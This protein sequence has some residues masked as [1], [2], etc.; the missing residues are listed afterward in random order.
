MKIQFLPLPGPAAPACHL[1]WIPPCHHQVCPDSDDEFAPKFYLPG[2][3][4]LPELPCLYLRD[5]ILHLGLMP[6]CRIRWSPCRRW[7]WM[8]TWWSWMI[9]FVTGWRHDAQ[10]SG[11]SLCVIFVKLS[12]I[13]LPQSSPIF[14]S[15][16]SINTPVN[17]Q[18]I[19]TYMRM[20]KCRGIYGGSDAL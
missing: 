3:A 14:S 10:I 4:L 6:T 1:L 13:L 16:R 2:P 12:V 11:D 5:K 19:L 17:N 9:V 8:R 15:L 20:C 7:K 18:E